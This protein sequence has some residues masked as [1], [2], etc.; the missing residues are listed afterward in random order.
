MIWAHSQAFFLFTCIADLLTY[1]YLPLS[2]SLSLARSTDPSVHYPASQPA[3]S[4][5]SKNSL[6]YPKVMYLAV[7]LYQ[8]TH[9]TPDRKNL[10]AKG[11]GKPI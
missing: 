5:L 7:I 10:P 3:S 6:L 1:L 11:S 8:Q 2:L 4:K 9:S